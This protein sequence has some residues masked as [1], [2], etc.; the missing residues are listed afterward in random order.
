MAEKPPDRQSPEIAVR[1]FGMDV[2]NQPFSRVAMALPTS[3][4][5][6][7]LR[8]I[9]VVLKVG[10]VIGVQSGA[11]KARFRITATPVPGSDNSDQVEVVSLDAGQDFWTEWSPCCPTGTF[12]QSAAAH[13]GVQPERRHFERYKCDLGALVV[14]ADSKRLWAR[15]SDISLGGCYLETWSPLPLGTNFHLELEGVAITAAVCTYHPNVGMGVRFI[16]VT[17]PQQLQ[18]LVEKLHQGGS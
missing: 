17:V 10:Q 3:N 9:N 5:A 4:A 2:A 12:K 11:A 8:G 18:V 6:V 7:C 1:V 14:A 16:E 13:T 15:C